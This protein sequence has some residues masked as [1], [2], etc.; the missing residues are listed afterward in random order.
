MCIAITKTGL[1]KELVY[2]NNNK[3]ES[4]TVNN[5][6]KY[7]IRINNNTRSNYI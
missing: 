4:T 7:K 5:T 3:L 1:N 6:S 2:V